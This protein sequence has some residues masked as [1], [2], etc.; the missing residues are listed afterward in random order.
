MSAEILWGV[1]D[2]EYHSDREHT[3]HSRIRDFA[4][5]GEAFYYERHITGE[6]ARRVTGPLEYGSALEILL[7][8]GGDAFNG[9]V[10]VEPERFDGRTTGGKQWRAAAEASGK[11]IISHADYLS[12]LQMVERAR[13]SPHMPLIEACGMQATLRG[14]A[15]ALCIQARPDWLCIAGHERTG[16]RP[17]SID[18]KTT[19]DLNDLKTRE[20]VVSLGY[21]TQSAITRALL[22]QYLAERGEDTETEH[23]LFV[24]EKCYPHR[25][26]LLRLNPE[27]LDYGDLYLEKYGAQL[28]A[29]IAADN[30]PVALP[31]IVEIGLPRR[32][33]RTGTD[34]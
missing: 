19:K 25:N 6:I 12:M 3:S 26:A 31:E 4:N 8:Q 24:V 1:T 23:Y 18:L 14:R 20:G 33:Q 17:F 2:D 7:Q 21:H 27:V 16:Y 13:L 9:R 32:A 10:M 34:S 28:A 11:I 22:R 30:W 15:Y 29:C 5:H